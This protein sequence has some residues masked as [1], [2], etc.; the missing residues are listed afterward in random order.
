MRDA[1]AGI[2]FDMP[3]HFGDASH[4][5]SVAEATIAAAWNVQGRATRAGFVDVVRGLFGVEL[6][7]APNTTAKTH[8][9]SALWLG[10]RSWLLVAGAESALVDF[11]AKRDAMNAT[12][13]AL[14]DVTASRFAW[15]ISGPRAATVLAT[16]CPLD[17]H[18]RAFASGACAQSLFG[19][20]NVLI[21]KRDDAPT[22]AMMAA[23]SFRRDVEHPLAVAAAQYGYD[24]LPPSPYR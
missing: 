13:G 4:G 18:P 24:V 7:I 10:P 20:V 12:G 9:L 8:A 2:G 5:V 3:G 23:R 14:F 22:F 19:H 11:A 15:T 6:P 1:Q 21:E 16:G 17:L